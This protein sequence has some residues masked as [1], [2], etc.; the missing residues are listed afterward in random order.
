MKFSG[1]CSLPNFASKSGEFEWIDQLLFP[2][3]YTEMDNW[4][5]DDF[6]GDR[7]Q[8]IHLIHVILEAKFSDDPG[9]IFSKNKAIY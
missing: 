5:F 8:L 3:K 6:S 1:S 7:S 2:L 4:V 9:T